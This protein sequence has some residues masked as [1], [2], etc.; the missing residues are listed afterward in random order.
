MITKLDEALSIAAVLGVITQ[1]EATNASAQCE[2]ALKEYRQHNID[3]PFLK[4]L[5]KVTSTPGTL[6]VTKGDIREKFFQTNGD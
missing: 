5:D 4:H 2:Y 1:D 6:Y 3:S